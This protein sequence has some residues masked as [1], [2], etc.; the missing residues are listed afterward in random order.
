MGSGEVSIGRPGNH[1]VVAVAGDQSWHLFSTTRTIIPPTLSLSAHLRAT[2]LA[3][4][5]LERSYGMEAGDSTR[6]PNA[7]EP[8]PRVQSLT[9]ISVRTIKGTLALRTTSLIFVTPHHGGY[10]VRGHS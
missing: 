1:T 7:R 9:Y 2:S 8:E 3:R 6:P 4:L 10:F 5:G